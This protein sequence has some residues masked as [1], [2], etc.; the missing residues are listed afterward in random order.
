MALEPPARRP[1]A[2]ARRCWRTTMAPCSA[3]SSI[4]T[5]VFCTMVSSSS[6]RADELQA[7]VAQDVAERV[8]GVDEVAHLVVA[9]PVQA[10]R[11]VAVLVARSPCRQARGTSTAAAAAAR[12][13]RRR[14]PAARDERRPPPRAAG[15]GT[16]GSR[17][18]ASAEPRPPASA[19]T[20]EREPQ[21][22]RAAQ[23]RGAHQD[24][25]GRA[26]DA[27][28]L[29]A[30]VQRLPA[31]AQLGCGLRDDARRAR[32][33]LLDR[34]ACRRLERRSGAARQR[35]GRPRSAA[36]SSPP[37]WQAAPRAASRS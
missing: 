16:G 24:S 5:G 11:V 17:A 25:L 34:L 3:T 6:S 1:A 35:R 10:E 30:A 37:P 27:E 20:T 9:R 12:A 21:G 19:P 33:R 14:A 13:R 2:G 15:R 8:V 32:E 22:Q 7:L 29:H 4:A 26:A 36:V 18:S 28:A 23:R 31:H